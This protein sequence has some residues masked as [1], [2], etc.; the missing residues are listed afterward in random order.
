LPIIGGEN[1]GV[2]ASLGDGTTEVSIDHLILDSG[3]EASLAGVFFSGSASFYH[4][5]K[6]KIDNTV[7]QN[8][9]S[10]DG[11]N[12]KKSVVEITRS[13]FFNNFA[14]Q[15]D[16]DVAT[17]KFLGNNLYI[18]NNSK[19]SNGDG[20]DLS[21]SD[22]EVSNNKFKN[23]SDKGIS[24]GEKTRVIINNNYFT[25]NKSDI[26]VKDQ[27][28]ALIC[29]NEYKKSTLNINSYVKK[30]FFSYPSVIFDLSKKEIKTDFAKGTHIENSSCTL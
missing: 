14:D 5:K 13:S 29:N 7:V 8:S 9:T 10:D 16:L 24:V 12:I 25:N 30:S 22:I 4:H 19:N 1:F 28:A 6:V 18:A 17:G 3:S 23:F 11:I 26:T 27:S 15:V 21:Y 20:L 2:L